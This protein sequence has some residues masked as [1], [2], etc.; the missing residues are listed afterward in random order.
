MTMDSVGAAGLPPEAGRPAAHSGRQTGSRPLA[1]RA[2]APDGEPVTME[3]RFP[4]GKE[5]P[6]RTSKVRLAQAR[7]AA[8]FYDRPEILQGVVEHVLGSFGPT[9]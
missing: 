5:Q 6:V 4:A 1:G 7:I 2:S 9:T 3:I 8:G